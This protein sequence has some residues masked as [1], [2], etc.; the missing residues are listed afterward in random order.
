[1]Q[2]QEE[3][4][5]VYIWNFIYNQINISFTRAMEHYRVGWIF[6]FRNVRSICGDK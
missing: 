2:T 5:E 6:F 3:K 1:M 4:L